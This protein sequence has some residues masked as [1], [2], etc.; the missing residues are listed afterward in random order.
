MQFAKIPLYIARGAYWA[1]LTSSA[2]ALR[3]V[4]PACA[5]ESPASAA[6]ATVASLVVA[7]DGISFEVAIY[8]P[9]SQQPLG[10]VVLLNAFPG[11]RVAEGFSP[12]EQSLAVAL[13][14]SGYGVVRFNYI[15]S[16]ANTGLFSWFGGV[17]DTE[18]VLRFLRTEEARSLGIDGSRIVLV[19]HSYG[20]W[21]ALMTAVRDPTIRCV[22]VMASANLGIGGKAIRDN[23]I[24]YK[25]S[26]A[27]Y[28][29]VLSDPK[30]PIRAQSATALADD[31]IEHAEAWDLL[32][33][34]D[35]LRSRQLFFISGEQDQF[36]PREI[37]VQPLI[38]ELRRSNA[39]MVRAVTIEGA[40]HNFR[41]Q[42]PQVNEML[43]SWITTECKYY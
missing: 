12:R 1:V 30:H 42:G 7:R 33:H 19:G 8:R 41:R 28:E 29:E 14:K 2:L 6:Q 3:L 35:Q 36:V 43:E 23:V 26:V 13:A 24:A 39:T 22:A 11:A 37:Y 10:T 20:G 40:D 27:F 18:A 25:R 5:A 17:L 15:G 34:V 32:N 21:V 16:W 38:N 31:T 9:P 4:D